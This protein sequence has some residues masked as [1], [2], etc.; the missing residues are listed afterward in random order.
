[1]AENATKTKNNLLA[2]QTPED[3]V[4]N[5]AQAQV[6]R[7]NSS[8]VRSY[9]EE[10]AAEEW[11]LFKEDEDY[12]H[13]NASLLYALVGFPWIEDEDGELVRDDAAYNVAAAKH[14][15]SPD[16]EWLVENAKE[17]TLTLLELELDENNA[18]IEVEVP[19]DN[20]ENILPYKVKNVEIAIEDA[21]RE[22]ALGFRPNGATRKGLTVKWLLTLQPGVGPNGAADIIA[23]SG[24]SKPDAELRSLRRNQFINLLFNSGAEERAEE[25]IDVEDELYDEDVEDDAV[26][27]DID[28]DTADERED[29]AEDAAG[30]DDAAELSEELDAAA[31]NHDE[32]NADDADDAGEDNASEEEVEEDAD[33]E[34]TAEEQ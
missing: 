4:R 17:E 31:E 21:V 14:Y 28:A 25:D 23:E 10:L 12:N 13:P 9:L 32:S 18:P 33:S 8:T 26:D 27:A 5:R 20:K 2:N 11:R 15:N 16:M 24:I 7:R 19:E 22:Y 34:E 1:M 6:V 29:D 30:E 3:I